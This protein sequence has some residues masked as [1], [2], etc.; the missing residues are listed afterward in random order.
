MVST[1]V[2]EEL[3]SRFVAVLVAISIF[4]TFQPRTFE[5]F[6]FLGILED[7][8]KFTTPM[9]PFCAYKL[10]G[11]TVPLKIWDMFQ[12]GGRDVRPDRPYVCISVVLDHVLTRA[13]LGQ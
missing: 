3:V 10:P 5:L 4:T 7:V 12:N 8:R 13:S 11:G 9:K 1:L 2:R 6:H